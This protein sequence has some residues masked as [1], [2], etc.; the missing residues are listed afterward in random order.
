MS[1]AKKLIRAK[2]RA[3]V[4]S[5]DKY[6]CRMCEYV[7]KDTSELDAHHIS[8]RNY[9]PNGG[10]VMENGISLCVECHIMAEQFH[11]TGSAFVGYSPDDLYKAIGH[12]ILTILTKTLMRNS[13]NL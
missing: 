5:R 12:H 11:S 6:K 7:P 8:D 10:Y 13:M 9:V 1:K 2:F 3:S 4:F